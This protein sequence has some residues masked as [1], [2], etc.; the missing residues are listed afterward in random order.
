MYFHLVKELIK[1]D[2]CYK[3][4][5][6]GISKREPKKDVCYSTIVLIILF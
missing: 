5:I 4:M 6:E 1:W 3:N 2:K